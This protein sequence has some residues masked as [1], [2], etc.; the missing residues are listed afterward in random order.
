MKPLL[1]S[2][3]QAAPATSPK[4]S[5]VIPT[6]NRAH[7]LGRAIDSI[8]AQT[9]TDWE[10]IV[11][12]DGSTDETQALM[13]HYC[14]KDSRI[15]YVRQPHFGAPARGL[16]LGLRLARGAYLHKQDDDDV[17]YADKLFKCAAVLDAQPDCH[18][19]RARWRIY[20]DTS[21]QGRH[22]FGI[23]HA[24]PLFYRIETVRA[25]GGWNEF[26]KLFE[27]KAMY[28]RI[29]LPGTRN[30]VLKDILYDYV[31]SRDMS[32]VNHRGL[33]SVRRLYKITEFAM[34]PL[35]RLGLQ[36]MVHPHWSLRRALKQIYFV[37]RHAF[38]PSACYGHWQAGTRMALDNFSPQQ[39]KWKAALQNA[40]PSALPWRLL[41]NAEVQ[42]WREVRD[43]CLPLRWRLRNGWRLARYYFAARRQPHAPAS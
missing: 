24:M 21:A 13:R 29:F 8:R 43:Q 6:Y 20:H 16:N 10:L 5:V 2:A 28:D 31:V 1:P 37:R 41:W 14:A 18:A 40:A 42:S 22:L 26:Y 15:H 36:A 39:K 30:A 38:L 7:V 35:C 34:R 9:L 23:W 17:A 12:D 3:L 25:A 19:A 32:S 11:V 33:K 4:V 27:D